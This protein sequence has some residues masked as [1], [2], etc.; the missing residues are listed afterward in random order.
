MPM[1]GPINKNYRERTRRNIPFRL[2]PVKENG[3]MVVNLPDL[4]NQHLTVL[5]EKYG[6]GYKNNPYL[7]R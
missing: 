1:F 6:A 2:L 3:D 7:T 5:L 4:S